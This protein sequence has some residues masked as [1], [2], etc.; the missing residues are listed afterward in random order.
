MLYLR[1]RDPRVQIGARIPDSLTGLGAKVCRKASCRAC[2][3]PTNCDIRLVDPRSHA[4]RILGYNAVN[5][6]D[7]I[8]LRARSTPS[9]LKQGAPCPRFL[10][11]LPLVEF[12][13]PHHL[14][15]I[16]K[17][18]SN[19]SRADPSQAKNETYDVSRM[20]PDDSPCQAECVLVTLR[21]LAVASQDADTS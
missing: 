20:G 17:A 8:G 2:A 4:T 12:I 13:Q 14:Q 1:Q 19:A 18:Q 5:L 9:A 10:D 15:T 11:H 3:G 6:R 16:P 7:T 21:G